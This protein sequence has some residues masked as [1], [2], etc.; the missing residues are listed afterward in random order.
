[1]NITQRQEMLHDTSLANQEHKRIMQLP[2]GQ[3]DKIFIA[4]HAAA[5]G[6]ESG[7]V[8]VIYETQALFRHLKKLCERFKMKPYLQKVVQEWERILKPGGK[9]RLGGIYES[10]KD[11]HRAFFNEVSGLRFIGLELI[12][13]SRLNTDAIGSIEIVKVN[14]KKESVSSPVKNVSFPL[15]SSPADNPYRKQFDEILSHEEN[16]SPRKM[17]VHFSAPY[18]VGEELIRL[19]PLTQSFMSAYPKLDV[20]LSSTRPYL[21]TPGIDTHLIR[22]ETYQCYRF[23]ES[24]D[25]VLA[26]RGAVERSD[27]ELKRHV[28]IFID[29]SYSP[30]DCSICGVLIKGEVVAELMFNRYRQRS[31]YDPAIQFLRQA[32][33]PLPNE[34]RYASGRNLIVG[35]GNAEA[36][37][38]WRHEVV[39]RAQGRPIIFFNGFGGID[40]FKGFMNDEK[41]IRIARGDYWNYVFTYKDMAVMIGKLIDNGCFVA[42]FPHEE[43]VWASRAQA[44]R[45]K[46]QLSRDQQE[47]VAILP[48][49]KGTP[50]LPQELAQKWIKYWFNE[51]DHVVTVEGGMGHLA[52]GLGRSFTLIRI[53]GA[54]KPVW[55]PYPL[56]RWQRI[57]W[58]HEFDPEHVHTMILEDMEASKQSGG[59]KDEKDH[60]IGV[61]GY[62]DTPGSGSSPV[63]GEGDKDKQRAMWVNREEIPFCTEYS[64]G[65][66][67]AVE[68]EFPLEEGFLLRITGLNNSL[69]SLWCPRTDISLNMLRQAF[70]SPDMMNLDALRGKTVVDMCCGG[71]AAVK[72]MR[73]YGINAFG[74]DI[75]LN[76]TQR[77]EML[78]DTSLANPEHKRIMQLPT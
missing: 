69:R 50:E 6:I 42:I 43:A 19:V 68:E 76:I 78:H 27:E 41:A 46:D 15:A 62:T 72:E 35:R 21:Y 2:T 56:A 49:L 23:Q 28:P 52:Y 32:G 53:G 20:T 74:L 5:T 25:I 12:G 58:E 30:L 57:I 34:R 63:Q 1:M 24:F 3:T 51:A 29:I 73:R 17:L 67:V 61:I 18:R 77:Q 47:Y 54:G 71:G 55:H 36:L 8:D 11:R 75:A 64:G 22:A 65:I 37:A 26:S 16:A 9:I 60:D 10:D 66:S 70:F 13:D 31:V 59:A 33:L 4:A 44:Q 40:E 48:G 45:V 7:S 14:E 38:W 39:S